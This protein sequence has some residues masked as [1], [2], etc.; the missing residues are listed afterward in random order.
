M[1]RNLTFI[2]AGLFISTVAVFLLARGARVAAADDPVKAGRFLRHVV[3]LNFKDDASPAQVQAVV[4]AFCA[5]PKKISAIHAFEWGTDVSEEN[6]AQG[7]T[8]CFLLTFLSEADRAAYLPH[9][10]HK[11]FGALLGP[12]LEKV[13]VVDYWA[14]S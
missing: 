12:V 8:H 5:L 9:P 14:E 2:S 7:Y 13:L 6:L 10:D 4:D 3:M 1:R 11:A